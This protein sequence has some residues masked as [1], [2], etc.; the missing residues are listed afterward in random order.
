MPLRG[1]VGLTRKHYYGEVLPEQVNKTSERPP[2]VAHVM[3]TRRVFPCCCRVSSGVGGAQTC[4]LSP[5]PLPGGPLL[6]TRCPWRPKPAWAQL[7]SRMGSAFPGRRL[8]ASVGPVRGRKEPLQLSGHLGGRWRVGVGTPWRAGSADSPLPG[9]C[10]ACTSG[11][12]K[13]AL[14]ASLSSP[15][16]CLSW[17]MCQRPVQ[18]PTGGP[19]GGPTA[20]GI[21]E[22]RGRHL[23]LPQEQ[24]LPASHFLSLASGSSSARLTATV[25]AAA[26]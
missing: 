22:A 3:K 12:R 26:S 19:T 5:P 14:R 18:G 17:G 10:L 11:H 9:R 16:L 15:S 20:P 1:D 21:E 7:G 4:P 2:H 13:L 25:G 8:L 6:P 23:S 24:S